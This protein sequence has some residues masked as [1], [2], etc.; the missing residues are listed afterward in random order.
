MVVK[1]MEKMNKHRPDTGSEMEQYILMVVEQ[2]RIQDETFERTG[3]ENEEFESNL[4]IYMQKDPL[5]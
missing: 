2:Y 5:I 3:V 1:M 4:H